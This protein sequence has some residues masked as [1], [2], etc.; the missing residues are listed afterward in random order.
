MSPKREAIEILVQ[1]E[2]GENVDPERLDY[3]TRDLRR[4]MESLEVEAVELVRQGTLSE[5]AKSG[6]VVTL[7]ALAVVTLPAVLPPL[8]QFL[9]A[10]SLRGDNR[11]VKIKK[12]KGDQSIEVELSPEVTSPEKLKEYLEVLTSGEG[13]K[14]SGVRPKLK[15]LKG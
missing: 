8:I 10:W 3:I 11:K 13:K 7:G 5:G 6:E 12:Q 14:R 15:R 1:I 4:E 2:L 9:Q